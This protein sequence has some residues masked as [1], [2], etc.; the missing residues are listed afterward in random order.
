MAEERYWQLVSKKN[1]KT[2]THPPKKNPFGVVH[3]GKKATTAFHFL[4]SVLSEKVTDQYYYTSSGYTIQNLLKEEKT[5]SVF[6]KQI[7][8]S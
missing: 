6:L 8:V 1:P 7:Q 2:P 4:K 5:F 3:K